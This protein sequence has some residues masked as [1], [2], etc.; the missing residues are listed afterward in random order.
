M[1]DKREGTESKSKRREDKR[2]E[3]GE[4]KQIRE[5]IE[6]RIKEKKN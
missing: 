2:T 5:D 6:K 1:R 4:R 3:E